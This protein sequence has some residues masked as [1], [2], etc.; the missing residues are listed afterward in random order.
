MAAGPEE[1][2]PRGC[3]PP[4]SPH[5]GRCVA[6][7]VA[8]SPGQPCPRPQASADRF[9]PSSPEGPSPASSPPL[10]A[11]RT[12]SCPEETLRSPHS[13]GPWLCCVWGSQHAA[14]GG[15]HRERHENA[16]AAGSAPCVGLPFSLHPGPLTLYM[17]GH[18]ESSCGLHSSLS[19]ENCF[20]VH[21]FV[22]DNKRLMSSTEL[23]EQSL[24]S[25]ARTCP[26]GKESYESLI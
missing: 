7:G 13:P 14:G 1:L 2:F 5:A 23:S 20:H 4:Q 12:V 17:I 16:V 8:C 21:L 18:P 22:S 15:V 6:G 25:K 10:P 9:L 26:S 19:V 11:P 3:S 24:F